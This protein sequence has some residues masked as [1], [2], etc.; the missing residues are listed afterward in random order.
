MSGALNNGR[1]FIRIS[2]KG[3]LKLLSTDYKTRTCHLWTED[4]WAQAYQ[5]HSQTK[6]VTKMRP[7]W[8]KADEMQKIDKL[9]QK[10]VLPK[11]PQ[12]MTN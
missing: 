3:Q 12:R 4:T 2:K 9:T 8:S 5:S 11:Q 1:I 6:I 10:I 7:L